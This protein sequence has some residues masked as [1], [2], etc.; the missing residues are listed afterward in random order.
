[1]N[2]TS[3]LNWLINEMQASAW[4]SSCRLHTD[5]RAHAHTWQMKPIVHL[6][7]IS[8]QRTPWLC[9]VLTYLL[10]FICWVSQITLKLPQV[11]KWG[12]FLWR[13]RP[14]T[15]TLLAMCC[16]PS[17][18]LF[19]RRALTYQ[20]QGSL[21]STNCSHSMSSEAFWTPNTASSQLIELPKLGSGSKSSPN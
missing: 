17:F 15:F 1:M 5:K 19:H 4:T 16:C 18:F 8:W 10:V 7:L 21:N 9:H 14:K 20:T 12:H 3:F 11:H 13:E 6:W 2:Y